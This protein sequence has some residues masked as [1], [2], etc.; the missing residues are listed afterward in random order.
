[1]ALVCPVSVTTARSRLF[2][3][4]ATYRRAPSGVMASPCGEWNCAVAPSITPEEPEPTTVL[5]LPEMRS[6]SLI[7]W[8]P[9]SAT[10]RRPPSAVQASPLKPL[11]AAAALFPSVNPLLEPAS[12]LTLILP[13]VTVSMRIR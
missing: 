4:S 11:N 13:L 10:Y 8:F 5:T 9:V 7:A 6:S 1:M 2:P 3:V 12:V